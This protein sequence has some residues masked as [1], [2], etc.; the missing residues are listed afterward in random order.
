MASPNRQLRM[1]EP[2]ENR[3]AD[4]FPIKLPVRYREFGE[5]DWHMGT[6]ENIGA[7]GI[8]F[9]C[10]QS[11]ELHKHVEIDFVLRSRQNESLGT[12]VV[13]LGEIVRKEFRTETRGLYMLAATIEEYHLLP[14]MGPVM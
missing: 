12:H 13:C 4:R 1:I 5:S 2:S 11:A 7:T 9:K 8:L 10:H 3:Q 14:W 6:T